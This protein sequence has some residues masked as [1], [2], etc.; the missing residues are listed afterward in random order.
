MY[1]L[2]IVDDEPAILC[3][4][5]TLIDWRCFGFTQVETADSFGRALEIAVIARPHLCLCDVRIGDRKGFELIDEMARLDVSSHFIMMSGYDEFSFAV[6]SMRRGAFDYLLKPVDIK[7]LESAVERVTTEKLGGRL[8]GSVT[9]P[10]DPVLGVPNSGFSPLVAK[11]MMI[12]SLEYS[13]ELNLRGI[14]EKF[15]MN[16]THLG[17]CFSQETGMKFSEYLTAYRLQIA[18]QMLETT[19]EKIAAV[20]SAAGYYHMNYFYTQFKAKFGVSPTD[21][22]KKQI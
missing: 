12:A 5:R 18:K 15:R 7:L 6:E 14:A 1:R 11:M 21:M 8:I 17:R 13:R 20:A 4:M 2:L 10:I 9:A 3:A 22:R 19:D 16:P